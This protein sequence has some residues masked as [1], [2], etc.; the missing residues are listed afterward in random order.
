MPWHRVEEVH[1][2][3]LNTKKIEDW[4]KGKWGDW[5]YQVEVGFAEMRYR[6]ILAFGLHV[7]KVGMESTKTANIHSGRWS[8]NQRWVRVAARI[9]R[10]L[11]IR[12]TGA[13]EGNR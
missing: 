6:A 10:R 5:D 1:D 13:D 7:D 4:L 11:T 2:Y 3:R 9:T 12:L 8:Q